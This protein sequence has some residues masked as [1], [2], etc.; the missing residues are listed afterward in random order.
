[1]YPLDQ[2]L[3]IVLPVYNCERSLHSTV[4]D[5]FDLALESPKPLQLVVVD[6]GSSDETYETACELSLAYPQLIVMRQSIQ[7]GLAAALD[8]VRCRLEIEMA[9]VHDG[10]SS[11]NITELR[12]LIVAESSATA[13]SPARMSSTPV[14]DTSRSRRFGS[15]RTLHESMEVAHRRVSGFRWLRMESPIV[16]RR[17]P[18]GFQV[19]PGSNVV[20]LAPLVLP[21]VGIQSPLG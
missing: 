2:P 19:A 3:T 6:D 7:R 10:V 17:K 9:I 14:L 15:V 20:P 11:I 1:M 5:I 4:L 12:E 16:P 13:E 18:I 21:P 8:L